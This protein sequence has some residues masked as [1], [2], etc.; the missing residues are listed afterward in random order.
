MFW[1]NK[2]IRKSFSKQIFNFQELFLSHFRSKFELNDLTELHNV[3]PNE[4]LPE[5]LVSV[6]GDQ[7]IE[8]YKFLYLIDPVYNISN[9]KNNGDFINLYNEFV[10]TLAEDI[11]RE[12]IVYQR[13]PTLRIHFPLN[14]SVGGYHRDRDYNHPSEEINIWVPITKATSTASIQI[15]TSYGLRDYK[16]IDIDYGNLIIFDSCLEHG[17]EVNT[18]DYTRLSFDFR[19]I[20]YSNYKKSNLTSISQGI[21]FNI[22]DYYELYKI[23]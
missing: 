12:D 13:L 22:G 21:S 23:N 4:W 10:G 18:M 14:L 5:E 3:I 6:E 15:E 9:P 2:V 8:I 11:F 19:V 17:N 1:K 20:P 7:D 16:S